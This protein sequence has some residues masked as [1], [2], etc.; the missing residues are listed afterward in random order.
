MNTRYV[1]GTVVASAVIACTQGTALAVGGQWSAH[2]PETGNVW[3]LAID[4]ADPST[5]YAATDVGVMKTTNGGTRWRDAR[6]GLPPSSISRLAAAA[7][8]LY[9]SDGTSV[10]R[11]TDGGGTW[12]AGTGL[13]ADASVVGLAAD[14][15]NAGRAYALLDF[16]AHDLYRTTDAGASWT[17]VL[18][19]AVDGAVRSVA[20]HPE[21]GKVFAQT[22][23][24]FRSST[25]GLVWSAT[26]AGYVN[27]NVTAGMF[28][29]FAWGTGV[30]RSSNDGANWVDR[31][32][33][34][35]AGM[36]TSLVES[37]GSVYVVINEGEVFRSDDHGA[38]WVEAS[39]PPS[40][41]KAFALGASGV[42]YAG[43]ADA[44]FKSR[45]GGATWTR[46]ASG[47]V[48]AFVLGVAV[49][50]EDP[51]TA[52]S[53]TS[54]GGAYKT[55][56][57]GATWSRRAVGLNSA[58]SRTVLGFAVDPTSSANVYAATA[59]GVYKSTDAGLT[60]ARSSPSVTA[61]SVAV[62]PDSPEIVY[63]ATGD[64]VYRTRDAGATWEE[65]GLGGAG[66]IRLT[67]DASSPT[68]VYAAT[69]AGVYKTVDGGDTW[70]KTS[71]GL[72]GGSIFQVAV[73]PTSPETLYAGD[74]SNGVFKS[75]DGG[76][77][78][79][80]SSF[81]LPAGDGRSVLSVAVDSADPTVVYAGTFAGVFKSIDSGASWSPMSTGLSS[82]IVGHLA[83][84]SMGAVLYAGTLTGGTNVLFLDVTP[85]T[86]PTLAALAIVQRQRAFSVGP[87]SATDTDSGVAGYDVRYRKAVWNGGTFGAFTRLRTSTT[88]TSLAFTGSPGYM[89]CFSVRAVD[90][91]GNESPWSAQRCTAVPLNDTALAAS[92]GWERKTNPAY[93]S[94]NYTLGSD[95]GIVLTRTGV[96]A[97]RLSLLVT[98]G[99]G[100]GTLSV[101]WNGT[102]IATVNLAQPTLA[103]KVPVHLPVF[104]TVQAGTVRLVVTTS[105]LPVEVDGLGVGAL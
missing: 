42:L 84:D 59:D 66:P 4:L 62:D 68:T 75:F 95:S 18:T 6:T 80:A 16:P 69:G 77:T 82:P 34:L 93:Y 45:D 19:E 105:G 57:G 71:N 76:A 85:P 28:A 38:T 98:K 2:G 87:W 33:G 65:S 96:K 89:Y 97:K 9:A 86:T 70:T 10:Y 11:S 29:I 20:V 22:A 55:T 27:D 67:I 12:A 81:G 58:E 79:T 63:A 48:R 51:L 49:D 64:G 23:T 30:H 53:G 99:P 100:M 44:V 101:E 37:F 13:P 31:S 36:I 88:A 17:P 54:G 24:A 72:A 104:S 39:P 102:P 78:W 3:A 74:T 43:Q 92:P 41:A 35:P 73:D 91:A 26:G 47:Y 1:L 32:A 50:A 83:T 15:G 60:W 7:D 21:N 46:V 25:D 90:Y 14:P 94:G 103:R 5:V 61:F 56:N 8:A 40:G 52:Y